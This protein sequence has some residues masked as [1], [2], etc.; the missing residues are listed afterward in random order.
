M[1]ILKIHFKNLNSLAG[2]WE[3]DLMRPEF[4]QEGCFLITG[5]TGAGKTTI[6][7]AISLALYGRTPR[8]SGFSASKNEIMS[9]HAS[10]CF[11]ELDF[12][13]SDGIF[14]ARW[15]QK[16]TIRAKNPYDQGVRSLARLVNGVPDSPIPV[17][18]DDRGIIEECLGLNYEQFARAIM[19]AQ[20]E[21]SQFLK[22]SEKEK[23]P[24]LEK[25]T[26]TEIYT[27]LSR[28][29]FQ[30]KKEAQ[31]A[32]DEKN[33]ALELVNVLDEDTI[34]SINNQLD[35]NADRLKILAAQRDQNAENSHWLRQVAALKAKGAQLDGEHKQWLARQE[36]FAPLAA[37]LTLALQAQPLGEIYSVLVSLRRQKAAAQQ[38][39]A[40]LQRDASQAQ[41]RLAACQEA[42]EQAAAAH[43]RALAE[44]EAAKPLL[45]E[46]RLLD[47]S[48]GQWK[49]RA[50]ALALK[51]D[52]FSKICIAITSD[53][54][55][56][57]HED[58]KRTDELGRLEDW[59]QSH[60][61]Y[62]WLVE[63]LGLFQGRLE[64]M[65][66]KQK[67]LAAARKD[68]AD[69]VDDLKR[70]E[71]AL[72]KTEKEL[73]KK[74]KNAAQLQDKL[75]KLQREQT[76]LLGDNTLNGLKEL[77]L[78]KHSTLLQAEAIKSLTQRRTELQA[79]KPCPLC[80]SLE[81]P[82]A[83]NA[84]LPEADAV[85]AEY[86]ALDKRI[87]HI[88][89][90]SAQMQQMESQRQAETAIVIN[91]EENYRSRQEEKSGLDARLEKQSGEVKELEAAIASLL[92]GLKEALRP[93]GIEWDND[94]ARLL[95]KLDELLGGWQA[96]EARLQEL[97]ALRQELA[98]RLSALEASLNAARDNLANGEKE[99]QAALG[100]LNTRRGKRLEKFGDKNP[101]REEEQLQ[102][103]VQNA[104][105]QMEAQRR[106]ESKCN[107]EL[108]RLSGA[109]N[110][111]AQDLLDLAP[112]LANG[113][114]AF[115]AM[116][117]ERQWD[118][119]RYLECR[120]NA[121]EVDNWL[122]E[123]RNLEAEKQRLDSLLA[124]NSKNLEQELARDLTR[125]REDELEREKRKLEQAIG[126]LHRDSA[127]LR[128]KLAQNEANAAKSAQLRE[129]LEVSRREF[130]RWDELNDLIGSGDG[131]KFSAFAQSLTLDALIAHA[132]VQFARLL[133]RYR[134]MRNSNEGA[135]LEVIDSYQADQARPLANL[136]GGETFLASLALALGLSAM[137][138]RNT[139]IGSLF[140]DEGFGSLDE[141][142][143]DHAI[144][145]IK[146]LRGAGKIIGIISHVDALKVHL[147]LQIE[148]R[149]ISSGRS[150]LSGPGCKCLSRK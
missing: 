21:F 50:K 114:Q 67:I 54:D 39:Q 130:A 111:I 45:D 26:N 108:A 70:R 7:D 98:S 110:R 73:A 134:F 8:L 81:H 92:T 120:Q 61:S 150:A 48:I 89:Q 63:N 2:E 83:M 13:T 146:S 33:K 124:A 66:E 137:A 60:A 56:A 35:T 87:S 118:E 91:L 72:E 141:D 139:P 36:R 62:A 143:L 121:A 28:H 19:L 22:A 129:E 18:K 68:M 34:A 11:A 17:R 51:R 148:V 128:E 131:K 15:S 71:Q 125:K 117:A 82:Y 5:P 123:Q 25:L 40:D 29:A 10:E 43:T 105:A 102:R 147:P 6:L 38:Q 135:G 133:D 116:L 31:A 65:A 32:V 84:A 96:S 93:L 9:R 52:D 149:P 109:A 103:A 80:G 145:A 144:E 126:N 20:G 14:R 88:E 97:A 136:S 27:E 59:R 46:V 76:A 119:A 37:R 69:A 100:E 113:E 23:A 30:K 86:E 16:R 104:F 122:E 41:K 107:G 95:K 1:R 58:R 74:H 12:Q 140:L 94:R 64:Q 53:L 57:K 24:I 3:V 49:D 112:Q 4:Q 142:T 47:Q 75:Q 44:A 78:A 77:L 42:A 138:S 106:E 99:A 115:A 101:A 90:L 55:R 85:R 79:G 127:Q 132:N